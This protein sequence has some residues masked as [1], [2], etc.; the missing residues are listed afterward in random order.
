M[1]EDDRYKI[2]NTRKRRFL[3]LVADGRDTKQWYHLMYY[4]L[5]LEGYVSWCIG[6]GTLTA[7]GKQELARLQN[8]A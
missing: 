7:E 4:P 8:E 5:I 1:N 6:H 3:S 2:S